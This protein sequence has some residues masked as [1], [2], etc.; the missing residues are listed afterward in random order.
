MLV[1]TWVGFSTKDMRGGRKGKGRYK[2]GRKRRGL[3]KSQNDEMSV[4]YRIVHDTMHACI[5]DIIVE[6]CLSF[7]T[8]LSNIKLVF[9]VNFKICNDR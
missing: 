8:I 5:A 7:V 3:V 6:I 1:F 9:I 2:K 4:L